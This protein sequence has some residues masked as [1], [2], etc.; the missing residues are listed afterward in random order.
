[1]SA[2][3][4]KNSNT[5]IGP[6][7]SHGGLA[8]REL[9]QLGLSP[10]QV[11][12]FSVNSNPYGP[13]EAVVS[14]VQSARFDV[15]PDTNAEELKCAIEANYGITAESIV[16]GNGA[17]D[18]L[19]ILAAVFVQP[20][21]SV[22][23]VEPTFC[24][25]RAACEHR[26]AMIH[27]WRSLPQTG[28]ALD[29][30]ALAAAVES[31][32]AEVVYLCNPNSPTGVYLP[33][34]EVIAF[35]ESQPHRKLILDQAFLSLSY[36]FAEDRIDLP[37]N[38]IILRSFTKEHAI[39]GLRLGYAVATPELV[40]RCERARPYWSINA[41]AQIA[42]IAACAHQDFVTRSRRQILIDQE[43]MQQALRQAGWH[44]FPSSTLY[45]LLPMREATAMRLR[46]LKH[47]IMTRSCASYALP[48]CLRLAVRPAHDVDRL[49]AA[50]ALEAQPC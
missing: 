17:A 14:A 47:G 9:A 31:S 18:L 44:P 21:S 32:K 8:Y 26:G 41:L 38:V 3:G 4:K 19:W 25:F 24:E 13:C 40:R 46:L 48:D 1:M 27:E 37:E 20:K 42:G 23:I 45:F 29:W 22:L 12:D 39:A 36:F 5:E 2:S 11:I 30:L 10:D 33:L 7:R 16:I 15:Y 6:S 43:S 50:L 34:S 49:I 28:F 35:A